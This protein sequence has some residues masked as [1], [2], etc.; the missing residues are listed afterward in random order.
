MADEEKEPTSNEHEEAPTSNQA[1]G[2]PEPAVTPSRSD[3][4]VKNMDRVLDIKLE[5]V[6][7]IGTLDMKFKDVLDLFPGS[8]L[9]IDQNADGPLDLVIGNKKLAEGEV[10]TVGENLGLRIIKR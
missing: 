3:G 8:V 2:A 7:K 1:V 9:E 10:V 4:A 5:L 6:V